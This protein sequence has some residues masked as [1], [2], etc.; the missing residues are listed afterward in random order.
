MK[1]FIF[2]LL[3]MFLAINGAMAQDNKSKLRPNQTKLQYVGSMGLVSSG[4]GW[5]YG[6]SNNWE[7][8]IMIGYIPKYTTDKAK[9]CMTIKENFIPWK[10]QLR[11]ST[12]FL[13]PLTSGIYVNTVSGEEFWAK[14]P[15]KYPKPYYGFSTKVRFNISVGQRMTYKILTSMKARVKFISAFY[16]ISSSDLYIV[17]AFRDSHLKPTQYLHLSLGIGFRWV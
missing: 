11:N 13:E 4:L 3:F 10:I 8:D 12:F 7:T 2:E 5:S 15:E 16:E 6:K 1:L 9:M 17:S 14:E